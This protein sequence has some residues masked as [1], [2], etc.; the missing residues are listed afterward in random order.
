MWHVVPEG[1]AGRLLRSW[2][3]HE[4]H[5][6]AFGPVGAS[7]GGGWCIVRAEAERDPDRYP[8]F[9]AEFDAVMPELVLRTCALA[10]P[11]ADLRTRMVRLVA[12]ATGDTDAPSA[13][14]ETSLLGTRTDPPPADRP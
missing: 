4:I 11:A 2:T 7:E 8:D 12:E 14:V 5:R 10:E 3:G 6:T 9:G 13:F 1:D